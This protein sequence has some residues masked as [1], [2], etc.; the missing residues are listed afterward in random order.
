MRDEE[1]APSWEQRFPCRATLSAGRE[2]WEGAFEHVSEH[3]GDSSTSAGEILRG[4]VDSGGNHHA[5]S[6]AT[7][8]V[9]VAPG[10]AMKIEK[11]EDR[12]DSTHYTLTTRYRA[13][14]AHG[15]LPV[16]LLL[17]ESFTRVDPSAGLDESRLSRYSVVV[18]AADA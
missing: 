6:P 13:R 4:I 16:R 9:E 18:E 12:L 10:I 17:Q 8:F 5:P 15:A 1:P 2:G 7:H 11:K 14:I 3:E